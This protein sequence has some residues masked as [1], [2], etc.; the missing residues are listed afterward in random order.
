MN[1]L[2][3]EIKNYI[4]QMTTWTLNRKKTTPSGSIIHVSLSAG[5]ICAI[6]PTF[7]NFCSGNHG[8]NWVKI[9]G[10]LTQITMYEQLACGLAP[11]EHVFCK[12]DFYDRR[13]SP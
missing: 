2:S 9:D 10:T 1:P 13:I 8:L 3:I 7:N 12:D 4:A 5:K 6:D 11:D